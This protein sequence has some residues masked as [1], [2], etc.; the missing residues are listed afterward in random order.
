MGGGHRE[1]GTMRSTRPQGPKAGLGRLYL[2][3][4]VWGLYRAQSRRFWAIITQPV[5][6]P[7]ALRARGVQAPMGGMSTLS[8]QSIE[9]PKLVETHLSETNAKKPVGM[10]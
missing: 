6:G 10:T 5:R 2:P 9:N 4:S 3:T 7:S 1:R 8:V